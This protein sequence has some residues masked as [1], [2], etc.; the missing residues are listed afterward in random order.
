[1]SAR[2]NRFLVEKRLERTGNVLNGSDCT[3]SRIKGS[4][5]TNAGTRP[6]TI[7]I[8]P[9]AVEQEAAIKEDRDC[10]IHISSGHWSESGCYSPIRREEIFGIQ[11]IKNS[12]D[13]E[14]PLLD[15]PRDRWLHRWSRRCAAN[16]S[17]NW[18]RPTD[19]QMPP[20]HSRKI[21]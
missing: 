3:K 18:R 11:Q 7:G 16:D 6:Q 20:G 17:Y 15:T 14:D 9:T 5:Q 8:C 19:G 21:Q 1:M 13:F 2:Q 12:D 10:R 4:L